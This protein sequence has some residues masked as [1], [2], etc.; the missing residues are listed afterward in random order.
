MMN[1]NW[2]L[3]TPHGTFALK[4]ITDVPVEHAR[5]SLGVQQALAA[6]GLPVCAPRRTTT[7]QAVAETGGRAYCL[8]PWA[9]G[10]HRAGTDLA[11]G[12]VFDLGALVGRVHH[13]LAAPAAGLD[14]AADGLRVKARTPQ[15]ALAEADRFLAII[16]G[17]T[18]PDAFDAAADAAL[19]GRKKLII[20][21]AGQRPESAI[22]RGPAGW[23]H[24]DL[25][26]L[27]L[28][29]D[30]GV[31]TA[32]LDWDRLRIRPYGE[33]VVR[34]ARVQFATGDGWDLERV[35][36]FTTGYRSVVPISAAQV[37]DAVERQWWACMTEFWQLHWHYDKG[38]HGPD[39]LWAPGE[40]LLHWWSQRRE[41][42][43]S[44]FTESR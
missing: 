9:G 35:A 26:P 16:A 1:R 31:I 40:R 28:L 42:V 3:E 27:N 19:R 22:A 12:E 20:T 17:R 8:L 24:G 43:R 38:D 5:R 25:Q 6:A 7:G 37:A 29:W 14:P 34:T 11:A 36:A 4:Q 33:E 10:E 15:D 13:A 32:V 23:T 44:A 2:R 41:Q 18:T 21:H 30:N 39:H